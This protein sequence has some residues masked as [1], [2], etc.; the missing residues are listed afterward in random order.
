MGL[1]KKAL[2]RPI[3]IRVWSFDTPLGHNA[4]G[5]VSRGMRCLSVPVTAPFAVRSRAFRE[6]VAPIRDLQRIE[7]QV[8]YLDLDLRY[9]DCPRTA[10]RLAPIDWRASILDVN[11]WSRG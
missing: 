3:S 2:G 10:T 1:I 7:T 9:A 11:L 8:V 6:Y 5:A 4:T